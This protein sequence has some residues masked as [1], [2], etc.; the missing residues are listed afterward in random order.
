MC[1]TVCANEVLSTTCI[2]IRR[3]L[4]QQTGAAQNKKR[5]RGGRYSGI[6]VSVVHPSTGEHLPADAFL[7]L[8]GRAG[9]SCM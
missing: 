9:D 5:P 7:A 3:A 4:Q 1:C 2:Q 6:Q 8:N